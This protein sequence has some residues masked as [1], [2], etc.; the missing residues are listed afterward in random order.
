[1]AETLREARERL[2][3]GVRRLSK[4]AP[5]SPRTIYQV[6]R[7]ENKPQVETVRKMSRF[8][9]VDPME[10]EEFANSLKEQ[11]YEA[12]PEEHVLAVAAPPPSS[13]EDRRAAA[14]AA[15]WSIPELGA[16]ESEDPREQ[17]LADLERLMR[18]VGR[19]DSIR[20]FRK[21]WGEEPSR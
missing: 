15:G 12:L 8:L 3:I 4:G 5:V 16:K 1:M 18:D 7:G 10:I 19:L 21:V 17:A 6:E 20:V 14:R 11:G 2:G 9:G 13:T